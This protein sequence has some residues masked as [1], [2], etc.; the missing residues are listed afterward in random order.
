M[1]ADP[2][3]TTA[4]RGAAWTKVE[5]RQNQFSLRNC[6]VAAGIIWAAL[7]VLIGLRYQL[8]LFA[9]GAMFSYSVAVQDVWAFHWHNISGRLFVY[10]IAEAPA[11]LYVALSGDARGGTDLYGLLFFSSP[12]LGL[13]ATSAAD[14]APGRLLFA[15]ACASTACLCPLVFGFPTEMWV[16]H[17]LFWPTL[18]V[19]HYARATV[20]R[21]GLVFVLLLALMFTHGAGVIL[22]AV[23]LLSLALRGTRDAVYLRAAAANVLAISIWVVVKLALPPD[24]YDGPMMHRAALHF[25]DYAI[26][27]RYV[28]VLLFCALAGYGAAFLGLQRLTPAKAHVYAALLVAGAL[29]AYWGWF[30]GLLHGNARYP[31]RTILFLATAA[32]GLIAAVHALTAERRLRLTW[33][34]PRRPMAGFS[35]DTAA[36]A[37]LGALVIVTLVHAIET[38]RFVRV[39]VVYT[40]AV[41][42]LAMGTASD[43]A[44]GDDRFV[45]S[46]R[47]RPDLNRLSWFSTTQF[48]SVLVAPGFRPARLVVDPAATYFWL[49][50]QTARDNETAERALP[51]ESRRLIRVH[52]C[53]HR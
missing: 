30:D 46:N 18:A 5:S 40:A 25:F 29:A 47:I 45:S 13:L 42:A 34:S 36:R 43:P 19:C 21:A 7:F 52:A 2:S 53:L 4:V 16:A 50:C 23:I 1:Q 26:V 39:W 8:Q 28:V 9:D 17:A 3:S 49:S 22:T 51:Q 32:L 38:A 24:A 35:G 31:V 14:R 41:R 12:L 27:T 20:D 6:V 37:I 44:L 10:L 33:F 48:L 11:E 15:Y